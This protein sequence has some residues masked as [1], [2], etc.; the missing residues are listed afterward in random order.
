[1]KKIE[2]SIKI[3]KNIKFNNKIL[4]Q[5]KLLNYFIKKVKKEKIEKRL[6]KYIKKI[7]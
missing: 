4:H 7:I 3:E 2:S 5:S 1:M 6:R